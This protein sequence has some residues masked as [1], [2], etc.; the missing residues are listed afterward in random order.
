MRTA[1]GDA[2]RGRFSCPAVPHLSN[3]RAE[4][5]MRIRAAGGALGAGKPYTL[6]GFSECAHRSPRA[7]FGF[8]TRTRRRPMNRIFHR[9]HLQSPGISAFLWGAAHLLDMGGTLA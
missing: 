3:H 8:V 7:A 5:R 1:R 6:D 9:L 4:K 2:P